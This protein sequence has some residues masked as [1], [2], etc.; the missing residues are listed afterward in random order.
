DL[1]ADERVDAVYIPLPNSLHAQWTITSLQAGKAVLCEKPLCIS[2]EETERVLEVAR[3]SK[4]PLWEALVF[5]FRDQ[6]ERLLD[7]VSGG[8]IGELR[9][10]QATFHYPLAS[11]ENI[12]L[13]AALGGGAL[14]DAG[15]Y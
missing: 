8:T 14:H 1:V 13:D 15:G 12:R 7:P 4:Q 3:G 5:L 6:T 11:R 2:A 9:E 10:I